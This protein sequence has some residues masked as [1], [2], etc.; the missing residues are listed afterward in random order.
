[1]AKIVI[2]GEG[3]CLPAEESRLLT[4]HAM[5]ALL[6]FA[7]KL[8]EITDKDLKDMGIKDAGQTLAYIQKA[9]DGHVRLAAFARGEADSRPD[10]GS[11][12]KDLLR[13][14]T[15]EQAAQLQEWIAEGG[16]KEVNR[17]QALQ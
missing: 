7:K 17:A 6:R 15:N 4:Q 9:M 1:M 10:Q 3:E 16:A 14:L 13:L 11:N 12:L 2:P 8:S 5:K